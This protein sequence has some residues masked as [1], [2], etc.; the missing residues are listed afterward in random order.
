M[1]TRKK[2]KELRENALL[3]GLKTY[4]TGEPCK[5]GHLSEKYTSTGGCVQCALDAA[6]RR[7]AN[8][9]ELVPLHRKHILSGN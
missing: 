3:N 6:K 9:P 7:V 4:S 1:V 5:K 2:A 8:K